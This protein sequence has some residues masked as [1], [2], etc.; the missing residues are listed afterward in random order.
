M[1]NLLLVLLG[2]FLAFVVMGIAQGDKESA[3]PGDDT[4]AARAAARA[5][6]ER[7]IADADACYPVYAGDDEG[8]ANAKQDLNVW[9]AD[10]DCLLSLDEYPDRMAHALA[11]RDG[12]GLVGLNEHQWETLL[13]YLDT[14][15]DDL[16]SQTELEAVVPPKEAAMI[17]SVGDADLDGRLG[18]PE[19]DLFAGDGRGPTDDADFLA[20]ALR[21]EALVFAADANGDGMLS[22]TEL[23]NPRLAALDKDRDGFV[24]RSEYRARLLPVVAAEP[25]EKFDAAD[26]D[27][28]GRLLESEWP[29]GRE[30][31][32]LIDADGDGA[33][34][35]D[36]VE[37]FMTRFLAAMDLLPERA[38]FVLLDRDG[39]GDLTYDEMPPGEA[40]D[41]FILI[42][43]DLDTRATW[44][45]AA[46]ILRMFARAEAV[47]KGEIM[48]HFGALD[49]DGDGLLSLEEFA[50]E[51]DLFSR[52]DRN[53][54]GGVDK[55]EIEAA[56]NA[57]SGGM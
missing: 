6:T 26:T 45:E 13:G 54:D 41:G 22:S 28:D 15:A 30:D 17:F 1:K 10:G 57:A 7:A 48:P 49:K 8:R 44:E 4:P 21:Q 47:K 16:V 42:D 23:P 56:G 50:I 9:D 18:Y 52:L 35:R 46:P 29:E 36:E 53:G 31:F 19:F 27:G 55:A 3:G 39:S 32:V 37:G 2:A 20:G 51:E 25:L 14:N 5:S 33:V 43:A 24:S 34:T 12:D 38:M 40:Q 11:D